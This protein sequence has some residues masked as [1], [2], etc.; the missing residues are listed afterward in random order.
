MT[1]P[2]VCPL[3]ASDGG[4]LSWLRG[5]HY[6]AQVFDYVE[7]HACHS[8]TCSPAPDA[9]TLERM[10]GLTYAADVACGLAGE[11]TDPKHPEWVLDTLRGLPP[12]TFVDYGC[13]GG[14]LLLAARQM[15]WRAVGVEYAPAV[16]RQVQQS[17]G[18]RVCTAPAAELAHSADVV[19]LGDV[20]EHLVHLDR[21][22]Q[23]VLRLLKPG[24]YVIAQG[25]LENNFTLFS[26]VIRWVRGLRRTP[27][28]MAPYHVLLATWT[29][30]RRFFERFGLRAVDYR[31]SEESWPA[32]ARFVAMPRS[33]ALYLLRWL[34]QHVSPLLAKEAGNRYFYVGRKR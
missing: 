6:N 26:Q 9:A 21:D 15:G 29:G 13:G 25:P 3:C 12:G 31:L 7:C 32:P 20:I 22:F 33:A 28:A 17:T 18:V 10:Y 34:S 11:V 16:A 8:L 27:V 19:H 14:Q 2:S 30:Q 5:V 24:G 23:S 1:L 4:R